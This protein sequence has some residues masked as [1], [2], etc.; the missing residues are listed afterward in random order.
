M[1]VAN[2]ALAYRDIFRQIELKRAAKS[3]ASKAL[4]EAR[5]LKPLTKD[6]LRGR[7]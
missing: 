7:A 4:A 5:M 6:E 1:T 3:A 2:I